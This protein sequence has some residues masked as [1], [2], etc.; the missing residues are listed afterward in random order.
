MQEQTNMLELRLKKRIDTLVLY[1]QSISSHVLHSHSKCV[2]TS[3]STN[4]VMPHLRP[5]QYGAGGPERAPFLTRQTPMHVAQSGS[6]HEQKIRIGAGE[7]EVRARPGGGLELTPVCRRILMVVLSALVFGG[8]GIGIGYAIFKGTE[9][10]STKTSTQTSTQTQSCGNTDNPY[11]LSGSC[12]TGSECRYGINPIYTSKSSCVPTDAVIKLPMLNGF[13]NCA[14]KSTNDE[15]EYLGIC[16]TGK[17]CTPFIGESDFA[18]CR[19]HTAKEGEYFADPYG[20]LRATCE[21]GTSQNEQT[22]KCSSESG[23]AASGDAA[24]GNDS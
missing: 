21:E 1:T 16:T 2:M 20:N 23:D 10:S 8:V 13:E 5:L 12:P 6:T 22:F 9:S 7:F 11:S 15:W 24:S 17:S 19:V 3:H 18:A 14:Q 4:F